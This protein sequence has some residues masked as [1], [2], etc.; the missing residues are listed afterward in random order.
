MSDVRFHPSEIIDEPI[1]NIHPHPDNPRRGAVNKIA[2]SLV[3]NGF[4]GALIVQ[5][6]SGHIL[7]GNHRFL[8]AKQLGL[9][10]VPVCYI[11]VDDDEAKRILLADNR[12]SDIGDYDNAV[13]VE[14][15]QSLPSLDGTAYEQFELDLLMEDPWR[16]NTNL[17]QKIEEN[18][19]G[20]TRRL[21]IQ[22]PQDIEPEVRLALDELAARFEKVTIK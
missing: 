19:D 9:S 13:L 4:Y 6:S 12:T 3:S 16:I 5:R 10:H 22:F 7:A 14:L 18:D 21:T 2:E 20:I 11:D 17:I 1:D 8:A 15:L